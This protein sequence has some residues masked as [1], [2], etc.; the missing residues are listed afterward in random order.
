MT[1][2]NIDHLLCSADPD[3][4]SAVLSKILTAKKMPPDLPHDF[5]TG[6]EHLLFVDALEQWNKHGV[7]D[8]I[9]LKS[10]HLEVVQSVLSHQGTYSKQALKILES[11]R[12]RR[13][14]GEMLLTV[15]AAEDPERTIADIQAQ[16]ARISFKDGEEG[17]YDQVKQVS[18]LLE[19]VEKGYKGQSDVL[20]YSTGLADLDKVTSGIQVG[21]MYAV[22]ALKKTGKSRFAVYLSMQLIKQG[23]GVMWESLEMSPFELNRC[24]LA[25]SV[26]INAASIGKKISDEDYKKIMEKSGRMAE[27]PWLIYRDK[28][29]EKIR[30]RILYER[31]RKK[32]IDVVFIDYLQIMQSSIRGDKRSDQISDICYGLANMCKEINVAVWLYSQFS[33]EAEKLDK[34]VIPNMRYLKESQAPAEAADV[35]ITMHNFD[36]ESNPYT[37]DGAYKRQNLWFLTVQRY[38]VSG[39]SFRVSGDLRY[40]HF[41]NHSDPYGKN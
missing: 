31:S 24:A 39:V 37:S 1:T 41:F 23:A 36:R 6:G 21:K 20:G 40:C 25:Y 38:D 8:S 28:T 32:K 13:Q 12:M 4:E 27:L 18:E 30:T 16:I 5:F 7:I 3:I 34:D 33:G 14:I 22:G 17:T 11:H 35:I 9:V 10:K 26:R 2:L 15:K 29:V 19:V